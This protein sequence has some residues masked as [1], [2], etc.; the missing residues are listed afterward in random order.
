MTGISNVFVWYISL[1]SYCNLL[2]CIMMIVN[3]R[4]ILMRTLLLALL[5]AASLL[6]WI[7][8]YIYTIDDSDYLQVH[9][10][11]V[12]QGDAI[13]IQTP[14]G[15]EVLIDGGV[16]NTVL[17]ELAAQM[18]FF[19][20]SIDMII[21]THPDSDHIGGLV[22]VLERYQVGTILRTEN[23]GNSATWQSYT[24]AVEDEDTKVLYAHAGQ[25]F[26][27]GSEV[28]LRVLYPVHD[29]TG[30]NSNAS[31]IILQVVYGEAE[32]LLTGDSPKR[33]EEYLVKDGTYL[34]SDV[35][36]VG[37]HGSRTS[38]SEIFL[39]AVSPQ[40]A[41]ISAGADN[42]YGHPHLEVTDSLFNYGAKIVSTV[43]E[44]TIS[45]ESDGKTVWQK[46]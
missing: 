31:S 12:G 23:T 37:H 34:E 40:Y 42:R 5:L 18:S 17:R 26:H 45:F 38:T 32:F 44:G 25:V 30:L 2:Q 28:L 6:L 13:F 39:E 36:K 15:V 20:R 3:E 7:P 22:D 21:G 41:V 19:D 35:L 24:N 9:F 46:K 1:I 4:H 10:L 14:D 16:N 43:T 8:Y 29:T 27:L 33:I 11:D